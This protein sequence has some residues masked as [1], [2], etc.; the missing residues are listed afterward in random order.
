MS[1]S[2]PPPFINTVA[3]VPVVFCMPFIRLCVYSSNAFSALTMCVRFP[4]TASVCE[5]LKRFRYASDSNPKASLHLSVFIL[6]KLVRRLLLPSLGFRLPLKIF[7]IRL[8]WR[9]VLEVVNRA[10]SIFFVFCVLSST[11]PCWQEQHFIPFPL[12]TY[13]FQFHFLF[14]ILLK[15]VLCLF[16]LLIV[17]CIYYYYLS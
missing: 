17:H 6:E 1:A 2:A 11:T 9:R 14:R 3:R 4:T 7:C 10:Q 8:P 5:G 16:T 12:I 13:L 15:H